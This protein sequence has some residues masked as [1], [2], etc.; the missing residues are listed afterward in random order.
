M[1]LSALSAFRVKPEV[2][3]DS[4]RQAGGF[5]RGAGARTHDVSGMGVGESYDKAP[6]AFRE[7]TSLPRD[8]S[9]PSDMARA[10]LVALMA[11]TV[12]L[13]LQH[14]VGSV[15]IYQPAFRDSRLALHG[16]IVENRRPPDRTW[17]AI[18]ANGT[19]IRIVTVYLAEGLRRVLGIGVDRVYYHLDSAALFASLLMLYG[20][21]RH[22]FAPSTALLGLLYVSAILPLTYVLHYFHPWDRIS[23]VTWLVAL[24]LIRGDHGVLLMA[25]LPFAVAVKFDIAVVPGLYWLVYVSRSTWTRVTLTTAL[26]FAVSFGT[27]ALLQWFLPGGSEPRVVASLVRQNVDALLQLHLR[28]PVFLAFA[29]PLVAGAIGLRSADRFSRVAYLFGCALWIP[30]FFTTKFAEVRAQMPLVVLML[31]AS[32]WGIRA[33]FDAEPTGLAAAKGACYSDRDVSTRGGG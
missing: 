11:A 22:W 4:G 19:N 26:L 27:F 12:T 15:T 8:G 1:L 29:V 33:L 32:L 7:W 25:W 23:L 18:G 31:P 17:D 2:N 16:Y 9:G 28:F 6:A 24:F 13:T 14:W 3:N 30:L 20:Y 10:L 5:D 21:L